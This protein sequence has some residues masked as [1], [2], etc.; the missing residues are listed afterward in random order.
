VSG[1]T[2]KSHA[3]NL[4]RKKQTE[5]KKKNKLMRLIAFSVS[6]ADDGKNKSKINIPLR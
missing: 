6:L 3:D 5:Q 1:V 4:G 2:T